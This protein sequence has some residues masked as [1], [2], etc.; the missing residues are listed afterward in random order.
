MDR[1]AIEETKRY[2][3]DRFVYAVHPYAEG[4]VCLNGEII[5]KGIDKGKGMELICGYYGSDLADTVAFGD[6]MNDYEMIQTAGVSIAMGNA[7]EELKQAADQVCED[8]RDDG[9]YRA[10]LRMGFL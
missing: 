1:K 7:C 10:F 2:L 4:S 5:P 8:V 6:S 9:I 3:G